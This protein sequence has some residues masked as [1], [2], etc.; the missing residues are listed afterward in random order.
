MCA[1]YLNYAPKV[2][3]LALECV[4]GPFTS[5]LAGAL[6][7]PGASTNERIKRAAQRVRWTASKKAAFQVLPFNI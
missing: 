4:S 7:S 1:F 2:H 3:S 6:G 5:S